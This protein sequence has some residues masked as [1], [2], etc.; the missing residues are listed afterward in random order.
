MYLGRYRGVEAP[1]ATE[2]LLL[3]NGDVDE[4][5]STENKTL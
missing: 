5:R 2:H 3:Y 4:V 1:G